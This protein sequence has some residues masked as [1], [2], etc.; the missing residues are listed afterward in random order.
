[1]NETAGPIGLVPV[2]LLLGKLPKIS[3]SPY[4]SMTPSM[5]L[6]AQRTDW[7]EFETANSRNWVQSSLLQKPPTLKQT[8]HQ[9][10]Q[11][12]WVFREREKL[13]SGL[14][15]VVS[16]AEKET[17]VDPGERGNYKSFNFAQVKPAKLSFIKSLLSP[18]T[19]HSTNENRNIG[20]PLLSSQKNS[21]LTLYTE[22][23]HPRD[24]QSRLFDNA[25]R[26]KICGLIGRA[27]QT[28]LRRN[29]GERPNILPSWFLFALTH[30][31]DG[32]EIYRARFVVRGHKNFERE[33]VVHRAKCWSN[34]WY[35]CFLL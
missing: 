26:K 35:K 33:N 12:G 31:K 16:H 25:K 10:G 30:W 6:G 27:F 14:H 34:L 8:R 22:V 1:M 19:E 9:P 32:T 15:F 18:S 21:P 28:L 24:P 20:S 2:L 17:H 23:T 3:N 13:W 7:N 29:A 5:W 4:E 11:S